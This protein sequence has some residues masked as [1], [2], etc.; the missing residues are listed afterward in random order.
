MKERKSFRKRGRLAPSRIGAISFSSSEREKKNAI[1][2]SRLKR[3]NS[4]LVSVSLALDGRNS[5]ESKR[6]MRMTVRKEQKRRKRR[7]QRRKQ[8]KRR[9]PRFFFLRFRSR[10]RS[11]CSFRFAATLSLSFS[12]STPPLP[13]RGS[14]LSHAHF[15]RPPLTTVTTRRSASARARCGRLEGTGGRGGG[16][17]AKTEEE[18]RKKERGGTRSRQR[19]FFFF[20][21]LC[22]FFGQQNQAEQ[23]NRL[24]TIAPA[25]HL[26]EALPSPCPPREIRERIASVPQGL[27]MEVAKARKA[28]NASTE[29]EARFFLF[30]GGRVVGETTTSAETARPPQIEETKRLARIAKHRVLQKHITYGSGD[31]LCL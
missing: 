26:E 31:E 14:P 15:L 29:R 25:K 27:E 12:F 8:K 13:L 10:R 24:E 17:A 1:A 5:S 30:L 23:R 11:L 21:L 3:S 20:S 6:E 28:R 18:R 7:E 22:F 16:R 19:V 4:C 9:R 2:H